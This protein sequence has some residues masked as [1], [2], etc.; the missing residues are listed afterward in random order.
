MGRAD[1]ADIF[2][3]LIK[4]DARVALSRLDK[5]G[6]EGFEPMSPTPG[7]LRDAPGT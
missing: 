6:I 3:Y 2:R 4:R 5:L 7:V 1:F